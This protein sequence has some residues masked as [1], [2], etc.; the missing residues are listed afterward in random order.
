[1]NIPTLRFPKFKGEWHLKTLQE[2]SNHISYGLTVRPEYIP[3]GIPLISA[4]EIK[5]G[6]IDYESAPK[7]SRDS[8]KSLSQK[9][10]PKKG[11]I[12]LSKTGT[13][14][15]VAYVD[16]DEPFAITQNIAVI[17]ISEDGHYDQYLLQ[18]L[19]TPMFQRQALSK[20]NKSTIMD[21]Q[22]GDI[23]ELTIPFPQNYAE[24]TQIASFLA[25]FDER[26]TYLNKK[27]EYLIAYKME[28]MRRIFKKQILISGKNTKW[29]RLKISD[30]TTVC[31]GGTPSTA[32]PEYWNGSIPWISSGELKD[33]II[34][35]PSKYITELGLNKSAAK[36]MPAG[37]TV[38]A[39]TGATLGRLGFLEIETSGNQSVAG[40]IPSDKFDSKFLYYTLFANKNSIFTVAAGGAQQG[41]NKSAIENLEFEYPPIDEQKLISRFLTKLDDAIDIQSIRMQ[42]SIKF[43]EGLLRK[44]FI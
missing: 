16:R 25:K 6:S 11:D 34:K 2:I 33:S 35:S 19:R 28:V 3:E 38:L 5:S 17:R 32:N 9:A 18:Y 42:S 30:I 14:G 12:F 40:F 43:K 13:V 24:Q 22:L 27:Y 7:I 8:F 20:V 39:M 4:R 44:L 29:T 31:I 1:M 37:T 26:L 41:I 15:L 36:I 23:R 21:L 10:V